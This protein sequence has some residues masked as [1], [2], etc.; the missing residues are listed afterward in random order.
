MK[1]SQEL[2]TYRENTTAILENARDFNCIRV[3]K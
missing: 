3:R 2:K 1:I